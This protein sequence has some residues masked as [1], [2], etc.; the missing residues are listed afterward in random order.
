M[1]PSPWRPRGGDVRGAGR[2]RPAEVRPCPRSRR[3]APPTGCPELYRR[4]NPCA[5]WTQPFRAK[6]TFERAPL[7]GLGSRAVPKIR[8]VQPSWV[9]F[10]PLLHSPGF[11]GTGPMYPP[12][13]FGSARPCKPLSGKVQMGRWKPCRLA[14][15]SQKSVPGDSTPAPTPQVGSPLP[16][17][18]PPTAGDPLQHGRDTLEDLGA[19]QLRLLLFCEN[20]NCSES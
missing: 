12:I 1:R 11:R 10:E 9:L 14:E 18:G 15:R 3:R 8:E 2:L 17:E 16:G 4:L 6:A 13:S 20:L 19:A 7:L 5:P